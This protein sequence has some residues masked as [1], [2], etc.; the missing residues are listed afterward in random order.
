MRHF[1]STFLFILIAFLSGCGAT[2]TID[3]F[4]TNASPLVLSDSAKIVVLGRRDSGHYETD[5]E[6]VNCI[7]NKIDGKNFQV[8]KEDAFLDA[9]YPWFEPR[10]A[11]KGLKRLKRMLDEPLI[12]NT[13]SSLDVHYL[14]WLNGSTET[15]NSGGSMSC[16][17]GPG[18]GGCFGFASWDK[19][20]TYEA[21]I[22]DVKNS[23]E[24][25][26]VQ[27]DSEGTSYLI[28]AGV[29]LP[30]LTPVHSDACAGLGKQLR[31]FFDESSQIDN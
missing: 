14:I 29:P 15:Q 12:S 17:I 22:W 16:A 1:T 19:I 23:L 27:V 11:P 21:V 25:G 13:L 5:R 6:F 24:R 2:T 28:G 30:F 20:S 10:T 26:R 4:R 8:L 3:E 7:G 31:S 18:G 9:L